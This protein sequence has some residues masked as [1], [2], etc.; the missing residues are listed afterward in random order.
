M[1]SLLLIVLVCFAFIGVV[2]VINYFYNLYVESN[3]NRLASYLN[4]LRR[5]NSVNRRISRV[6]RKR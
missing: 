5:A 3:M 4:G 1:N 6:R 2:F